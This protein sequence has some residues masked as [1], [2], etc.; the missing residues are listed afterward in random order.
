LTEGGDDFESVLRQIA[1]RDFGEANVGKAL[2]AWRLWSRAADDYVPTDENQYGPCRIGAAYPYNFYGA[3]LQHGWSPPKDFPLDPGEVFRI[4]FFDFAK[5][6][7]GLGAAAVALKEEDED[8]EI[9]LFES[10]VKD[11]AKGVE[12]MRAIAATLP[13]GRREEAERQ[14]ALGLYLKCACQTVVNVKRGRR[15][16][17][18]GNRA[19]VERIARLE[20]ANASEALAAVDADSRL[21]WLCSSGY[22]GGRPQIE[23][24][25]RK[26]RECYGETFFS[27]RPSQIQH[28]H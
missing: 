22:T 15:A 7:P 8:K 1:A 3:D 6:I 20:Y 10:Q 17:R 24:K 5:P 21:G 12:L 14:A 18:K 11:Y 9:E 26:M 28:C 16:F 13:E 2:D 4:C 23:W 25:L 19:E 27:H